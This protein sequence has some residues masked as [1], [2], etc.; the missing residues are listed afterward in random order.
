MN[1]RAV[2]HDKNGSTYSAPVEQRGETWMMLTSDGWQQIVATFNDDAAGMLIFSHYREEPD[3]RLHVELGKNS[4]AQL[5]DAGAKA[6][7]EYQT[8]RQQQRREAL[9]ALNQ[10]NAAKIA[11]ARVNST[12]MAQ[13]WNPKRPEPIPPTQLTQETIG[14]LAEEARYRRRKIEPQEPQS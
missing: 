5:Q 13:K 4:F 11:E 14:S 9:D 8:Q 10:P 2:Y 6:T 1:Y 12:A 7:A 3:T